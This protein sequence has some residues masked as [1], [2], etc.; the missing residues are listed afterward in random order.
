MIWAG[1][2]VV[3]VAFFISV[4]AVPLVG[5]LARRFGFMDIPGRH[6]AHGKAT[7]LLGGCAIFL[8]ILAPSFLVLAMA[9]YWS[10]AGAASWLPAQFAKHIPGA[11]SKTPMAL[12]I[13]GAAMVLHVMGLI[14]DRK[15]LGPWLKLAIQLMVAATVVLF[16][17]VRILTA[18]GGATSV[19]LSIIWLIVI[20]NAFNFLDNMDG[21]S[22]G[23]ALICAVGLLG[24]AAGMGQIF[25]SGWLCLL[26]GSL[27]GF[28][29]YN[30]PPA[31]I[32]MGDGG[33]L[34]IGFLLG[35]MSCLI[36]YVP[37]GQ[38][39]YLYGVFVPLV[40]MAVPLYDCFSVITIRLR[41]R[42]NPMVGDRRH[43][44]HRL[45]RRGMSVRQA[46]L[47]IYSC[48]VATA[49]SATLLTQITSNVGA[50]L[51]F[52][53]TCAVLLVVAMLEASELR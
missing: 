2:G 37:S 28:L 52:A 10:S 14:D 49:I 9:S 44:S 50:I 35:V 42:R 40:L 36:T 47:T 1:F 11:A 23:V 20:M 24:A 8:G 19:I 21:L 53:Q 25:V 13:L 26:I 18:I 46:V 41:E 29:P 17:N 22:A 15:H 33:S 12:G 7:P 32:F 5:R 30:F 38:I 48:T 43:F 39:Y 4:L 27:A 6:K 34:V 51:V 3:G 45:V 31:R 16:C